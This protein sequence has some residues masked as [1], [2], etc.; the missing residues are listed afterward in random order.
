M[1]I[2]ELPS[3]VIIEI[4]LLTLHNQLMEIVSNVIDHC[5]NI[6]D[7]FVWIVN[8]EGLPQVNSKTIVSSNLFKIKSNAKY[9]KSLTQVLT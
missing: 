5:N 8:L 1:H 3:I 7:K 6:K 9:A 4:A 2:A